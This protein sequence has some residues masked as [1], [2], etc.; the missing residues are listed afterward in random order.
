MNILRLLLGG[1]IALGALVATLL[2]GALVVVGTVCAVFVNSVRRA[3]L[4][5]NAARAGTHTP[6]SSRRSVPRRE[7]AGGDFIDVEVTEVTSTPPRSPAAR[8]DG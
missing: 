4:G 8:L 5:P 1:L 7:A 3:F 6:R 2:V